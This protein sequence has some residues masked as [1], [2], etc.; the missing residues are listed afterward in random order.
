VCRPRGAAL[1]PV[2]V[3]AL[4]DLGSV[5]L[6]IPENVRLQLKPEALEHR[7]VKPADGSRASHPYVGPIVLR[8]KNR[9]GF[10]GALVLA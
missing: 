3:A 6:C 5:F 4:A 7:E 2:E 9:T 8:F 1:K 10:V